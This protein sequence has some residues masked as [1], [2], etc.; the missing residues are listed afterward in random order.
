MLLS[1]V[2]SL[3]NFSISPKVTKSERSWY[4]EWNVRIKPFNTSLST[5][6]R[7]ELTTQ[8]S[9]GKPNYLGD[10][11]LTGQT[12]TGLAFVIAAQ[13]PNQ[14]L[15]SLQNVQKLLPQLPDF[16]AIIAAFKKLLTPDPRKITVR[17]DTRYG[18][19]VKDDLIKGEVAK[20]WNT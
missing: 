18:N 6:A 15:E 5:S 8:I 10:T 14:F 20:N 3:Q 13:D 12:I 2:R 11:T 7:G 17:V 16:N 1:S 19:F 9:A 4:Q